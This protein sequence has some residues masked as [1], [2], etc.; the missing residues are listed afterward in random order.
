MLEKH[1][2]LRG[3][4]TLRDGR[5]VSRAINKAAHWAYQASR[6][7]TSKIANWIIKHPKATQ[8]EFEAWLRWRYSQP[9]LVGRFPNG[10]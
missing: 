5:L 6:H 4:Y 10:I 8:E 1:P 2:V 9:D 3:R 7:L